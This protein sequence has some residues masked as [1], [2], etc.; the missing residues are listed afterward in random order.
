MGQSKPL[1]ILRSILFNIYMIIMTIVITTVFMPVCV[2][3]GAFVT[4][5]AA[6]WYCRT[7]LFGARWICGIRYEIRGRQYIPR[8]AAIVA[9]KH[10]SA[11]ETM[12][13]FDLLPAPVFVLKKELLSIPMVGFYFRRMKSIVVDRK[14]GSKALKSMMDQSER[15]IA[16]GRPI[17]IFPEGT[18]TEPGVTGEYQPG[19]AMLYSRCNVPVVPVAVNS[20]IFWRKNAFLKKPGKV[21]M[22]FLP[23]IASDAFRRDQIVDVLKERIE[24]AT[25]KLELEAL[26]GEATAAGEPTSALFTVDPSVLLATG[27]TE[28]M[29]GTIGEQ[30]KSLSTIHDPESR[31]HFIRREVLTPEMPM[32]LHRALF[33]QAYKGW[34]ESTQGPRIAWKPDETLM[35]RTNIG[36]VMMEQGLRSV[37]ALYQWSLNEG[38]VFWSAMVAR[39]GVRF[40]GDYVT[41]ADTVVSMENPEA[42]KWFP[43]ATLNIIDS[44]FSAAPGAVAIRYLREG[45][46][47]IRDVQYRE[48]DQFSNMVANALVKKGYAKGD[49][50]AIDMPMNVEAVGIFLGIL[51]MGG[52][53]VSLADSFRAPDIEIRIDVA[54]PVKAV[55]TQDFT[56]GARKFPLYP[57][58]IEAKNAPAAIVVSTDGVLPALTRKQDMHFKDFLAGAEKTFESVA[59]SPEDHMIIIFSSSTSSPKEKEGDKPKPPK[60][61]PWKANTAIKSAIDAHLHH[62]MKA[63]KTLCWPTNLGWMMGAFAIFGTFM[64][65][66]TLALFDGSPVSAEFC[67]F[68][69]NTKVNV[70]GLVPSVAEGWEQKNL[71]EGCDWSAIECFS[72]TGSPSNPSNYFY[73]MGRAKNYRPV[74]EYMGGTEIGG[75]YLTASL[76]HALA[77]STFSMP[78]FGT[79]LYTPDEDTEEAR[80]GE[81]FIVMRNGKSE[82]AAMG[83]STELLN[84]DH[85]EKYFERGMKSKKG[86]LLR[87][88]GDVLIRYPNGLLASGGRS[89]DGMNINGI[90][91]SSLDL[92]NYIK[93]AHIK[94]LKDVAAIAVRPPEGGEDWLVVYVTV[95]DKA[96]TAAAL[97]TPIRDAIKVRNPQLARVHDVVVID[98]LPLTAS[99]KLRRR[100]LQDSYVEALKKK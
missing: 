31:W 84:F 16:Q 58:V 53:V 34:D 47:N 83:L 28:E 63:G 26:S 88:H 72:S 75:A 57:M 55:F 14:A 12:A 99:G 56:G 36:E 71:T 77:P 46:K 61:I 21:I 17:I 78:A 76:H 24:P 69:E 15:R 65:R 82:C 33:D 4:N 87:E 18:R 70:L 100:Y 60:A 52:V 45:E 10:Q 94:G 6:R 73:L 40:K 1:I 67:Q 81:V 98:T 48:L 7:M 30:L 93:D 2:G 41:H 37:D 62:N 25:R 85:H 29:A 9:C 66:G 39:I 42:P 92:E 95:S 74:I 86:D 35:K 89:D 38:R 20:G 80:K 64:N 32:A 68:I 22:E 49:R 44:C 59:L 19:I 97:K 23:P 51:K 96:L 79:D 54:K 50:F 27:I 43:G 3:T 8:E 13:F 90:K 11:W 91:T 5:T